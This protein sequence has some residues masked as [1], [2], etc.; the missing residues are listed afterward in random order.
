MFSVELTRTDGSAEL[1]VE[2]IDAF[3]FLHHICHVTPIAVLP[4]ALLTV[5]WVG[6]A[7]IRVNDQQTDEVDF[8]M[9]ETY[10]FTEPRTVRFIEF[11]YS[12][13]QK[14]INVYEE[15]PPLA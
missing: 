8:K 1:K 3:Y 15:A 6:K 11:I 5:N 14:R 2:F 4:G 9:S 13:T 12:D 7:E 10:T